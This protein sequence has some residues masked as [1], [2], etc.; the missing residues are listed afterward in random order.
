MD[1]INIFKLK[2]K[3]ANIKNKNLVTNSHYDNN[4]KYLELSIFKNRDIFEFDSNNFN[5]IRTIKF[6]KKTQ[7]DHIFF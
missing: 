4:N 6:N 3:Y 1:K 7:T 2:E 5:L